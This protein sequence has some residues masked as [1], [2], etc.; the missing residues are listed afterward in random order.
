[1]DTST[2][3]RHIDTASCG[4]WQPTHPS[5]LVTEFHGNSRIWP[6]FREI[7]TRELLVSAHDM[8]VT[9]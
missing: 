8:L 1:M 9:T 2:V 4:N 3:I 7:D 6:A 5:H